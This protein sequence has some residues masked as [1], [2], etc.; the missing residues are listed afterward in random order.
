MEHMLHRRLLLGTFG[1]S[2][3]IIAIAGAFAYYAFSDVKHLL[4]VHFDAFR[5]IDFLGTPRDVFGIAATALAVNGVNA[6][7]AGAFWKRYPFLAAVIAVTTL[8]FS[9]FVALTLGLIVANN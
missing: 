6:F 2:F 3:A 5:G 8:V 9:L 1:A 7:L 4:I